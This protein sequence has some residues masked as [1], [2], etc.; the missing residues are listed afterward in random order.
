[1]AL[2]ET[3]GLWP[4]TGVHKGTI[5]PHPAPAVHEVQPPSA[6][7]THRAAVADLALWASG[8]R[9]HP[10]AHGVE[11]LPGSARPGSA[12]LDAAREWQHLG[13]HSE[14][15]RS[16]RRALWTGAEPERAEALR[17]LAVALWQG[18]EP[19][20]A[21]LFRLRTLW[22]EHSDGHPAAR[23]AL[24]GPLAVLYGMR[25]RWTEA[26]AALAV[27]RAATAELD[28]AGGTV[29]L[30]LLTAEVESLAGRYQR[31]VRLR[32]EAADAAALLGLDRIREAAAR[33][34]VR[35]LGEAARPE[36]ETETE[37]AGETE[38]DGAAE[39]LASADRA[40][41]A[42]AATDSPVAE[43]L[44]RL[45]RAEALRLSGRPL[46]ARR[47]VCLAGLCFARKGH[48]PGVSRAAARHAALAS[49]DRT[50]S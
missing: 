50:R 11:V 3:V 10:A 48:V 8:A 41:R 27:T 22:A 18:P 46:D 38:T 31:S 29:L 32:R 5:A 26:R 20:S 16:A 45:E 43:A 44:A 23:L 34:V 14:A 7:P 12:P 49:P 24:A 9:P 1:M 2:G 36:A 35:R 40:V 47:D 4:G 39:A 30:P 19:A 33:A 13:R 6:P 25:E 15:A 28:P 21:A 37:T 17:I 42:A